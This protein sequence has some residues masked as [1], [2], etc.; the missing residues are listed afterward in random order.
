MWLAV[1]LMWNE[2]VLQIAQILLTRLILDLAHR[3]G[4]LFI[5]V[6]T[7][8][9]VPME[10]MSGSFEASLVIGYWYLESTLTN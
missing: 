9:V 1:M 3:N 7:H 8:L 4:G 6:K 5:Q 2:A 10:K